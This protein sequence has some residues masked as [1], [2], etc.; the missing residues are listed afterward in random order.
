VLSPLLKELAGA[1]LPRALV[2]T[3]LDEV[4]RA[5]AS[6]EAMDKERFQTLQTR[7]LDIK[8]SVPNAKPAELGPLAVKLAQLLKDIREAP[9]IQ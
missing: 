8:T 6:A 3:K 4:R 5:L 7:F 2:N 9:R 1:P